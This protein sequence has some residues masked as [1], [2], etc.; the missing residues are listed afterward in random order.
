MEEYTQ[1]TLDM[2]MQWKEDIRR[3]LQETAGNFVYI[4]YRLRQIRDSGMLRDQ[5]D[6]ENIFD[7]A[8]KEYGLDRST[9]SRFMAINEKYSEGGY[10]IELQEKYRGFGQSQL[11]E[12]LTLPD[13]EIELITENMT[14]KEIRELKSFSK[15]EEAF[16][17][18]PEEEEQTVP[19]PEEEPE[20]QAVPFPE[21]ETQEE[22]KQAAGA[23]N[24]PE[25]TPLQKCIIDFFKDKKELLK[26]VAEN[27]DDEKAVSE[28]LAPSGVAVH[29]FSGVFI[30][31]YDYSKGVKYKK[32]GF[33]QYDMTW[34]EFIAEID[35]VFIRGQAWNIDN[36]INQVYGEK[37]SPKSCQPAEP[38]V[39]EE[40]QVSESVQKGGES[41]QIG[42][43][44]DQK[45]AE[46]VPEGAESDQ[47]V[48]ESVRN[49]LETAEEPCA[50]SHS[51]S[52]GHQDLLPED[53]QVKLES[54]WSIGRMK[55][56][57]NRYDSM[58][59]EA[60]MI[61]DMLG[62]RDWRGAKGMAEALARK[63]SRMMEEDWEELKEAL[64]ALRED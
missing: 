16:M 53:K 20:G 60:E 54:R 49:E 48:S 3:K 59:H 56:I 29:S 50:T 6:C 37:A 5:E 52:E 30:L 23:D 15:Q 38:E 27:I 34:E 13:S 1:I 61:K 11:A 47:N 17:N 32:L 63:A 14:V 35:A 40:K 46:S 62:E 8:K 9:V 21:E 41:D 43:E 18:A 22:A 26:R 36:V 58:L 57:Q 55:T 7:F 45:E 44:N 12:M 19:F 33:G 2:W 42:A 39:W 24:M 28:M 25:W 64:D 4:G 31:M 51:E 10:S